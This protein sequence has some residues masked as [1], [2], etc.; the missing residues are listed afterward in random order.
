VDF[1]K[2]ASQF[3]ATGYS[4]SMESEA[5]DFALKSI[6]Q[7]YGHT[8]GAE[9]FFVRLKNKQSKIEKDYIKFTGEYLATHPDTDKRI[10]KILATQKNSDQD[11]IEDQNQLVISRQ[12]SEV[13]KVLGVK[14]H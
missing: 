1:L 14:T 4:R 13:F 10:A 6:T 9:S 3:L 7:V 2:P 8:Y 12:D 5:D 11:Q